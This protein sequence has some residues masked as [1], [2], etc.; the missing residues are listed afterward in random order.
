MNAVDGGG[1]QGV[2]HLRS[3]YVSIKHLQSEAWDYY[4]V[5]VVSTNWGGDIPSLLTCEGA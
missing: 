3:I 4:L 5:V 2:K 1:V